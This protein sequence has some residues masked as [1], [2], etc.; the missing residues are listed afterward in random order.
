M[1]RRAPAYLTGRRRRHWMAEIAA[2]VIMCFF[3]GVA[4]LAILIVVSV[5][6]GR[7]L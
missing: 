1:K 2:K 7:G 5:F 3:A 6:T 4:L